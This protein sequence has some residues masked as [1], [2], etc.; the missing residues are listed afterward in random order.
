MSK[1]PVADILADFQ[2]MRD[3][4]WAYVAGSSAT[5]K[6]DCSGA[7]VWAYRQHGKSIYHGSNRI[8]REEVAGLL[9]VKQ[10]QP[11]MA[12]FKLRAPNHGRYD[13]PSAYKQG[14][15]HYNGD[16]NDYYHIG[17]MGENGKVLNA[18]STATGFVESPLNDWDCVGYLNQVDYGGG[19]NDMTETCNQVLYTG[20]VVAQTGK[21]VNLRASANKSSNIVE[22]VKIG[23]EVNV[24]EDLGEWLKVETA[25]HQGYMMACYVVQS[26]DVVAQS[27][28]QVVLERLEALEARIQ[29]LEGGV[30]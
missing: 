6:V 12:V 10:A 9:P 5:G 16:I 19:T 2:R 8:A 11:G 23:T 4:H 30:G 1:I 13:L 24:L 25:D 14:G 28:M 17:L 20:V 3:N 15:K 18:Q 7:F 21:T 27:E 26:V 22:R 29:A